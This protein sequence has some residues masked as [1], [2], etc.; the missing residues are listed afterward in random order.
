MAYRF[1]KDM[2]IELRGR[3]Y[4]I[5]ARLPDGNLRLKD[6][7]FNESK[8]VPEATLVEALFEG[9]MKFLG[10]RATTLVQRKM[11]QAFVDDLNMLAEDDPRRVE[12]KRRYAYV[13]ALDEQASLNLN[14][15]TIKPI[16]ERVHE[17][18]RDPKN[19]PG[20]KIVYYKWLAS[21]LSAGRDLRALVPHYENR[22]N[23]K[24]RFT[25]AAKRAGEKFS[26][27]ERLKAAEVETITEDVINEQYLN[28]QRLSVAEVYERLDLRIADEN[29]YRDAGD[30]LPIPHQSSVYRIVSRLDDYEKDAARFG[31]RFADHKHRSNKRGAV[32]T[33][34]LERVE[35]DDTR[36][37]LFV[38]DSETRLPLGRATLTFGIDCYSRMPVGFHLGFDGPGYL[39]VGQCLIHAVTPKTYLTSL[40]PKVQNQ[41]NVF[42]VPEEAGVDNGSAYVSEAF[43]DACSQI[44]TVIAHAP[45]MTPEVKARVER[46]FGTLN[47]RLL[48]QQAGTSFSNIIDRADYDPK[49]NAVISF[50]ALMEMAHIFLIDVYAQSPHRGLNDI[51]AKVWNEGIK[52][53]PPALPRRQQDLRVLLGYTEHRVVGPSGIELFALHYNCD[54][55]AL[56]RRRQKGEKVK[57][58]YNPTDISVIFAFDPNSDRYITVPALDQEYCQGLS[59]W[60]HNVIKNYVRTRLKGSVDKDGLRR[61]KRTIQDIVDVEWVKG[62][63]TGTRAKMA[64]WNGVRQPDYGAVMESRAELEAP[65]SIQIA[66]K[67]SLLLLN[68][69]ATLAESVSDLGNAL[70][71]VDMA[72]VE[73]HINPPPVS[74]AMVIVPNTE[75]NK[76]QKRRK[77][78]RKHAK[79]VE[80][81]SVQNTVDESSLPVESNNAPEDEDLD[82]S[83]FNVSFDLP[84]GNMR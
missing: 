77:L 9:E 4:V 42:G 57:V 82:M 36:T 19:A 78:S 58:K 52:Q 47:R 33:R 11:A 18:I 6:V 17:D 71:G 44:G 3:E 30:Q 53:Y 31:K 46:F 63:K 23:T 12:A 73:A 62:G 75:N 22:G 48:H 32:Y 2:H 37:D 79:T 83:G 10:D 13:K 28:S 1:R 65:D 66:A 74:A 16:I 34:P 60:Q 68:A 80:D 26:E 25:T 21:W 55:L 56:L 27:S 64:R 39:A 14:E 35:F 84:V 24:P 29:R 81:N 40:F 51:P 5:E 41:W 61:A 38:V 76:G 8:P 20:W 54:E 72:T 49:Q 7:A 69:G 43:S 50:D 70:T 45:V 67:G 15:A 59:L